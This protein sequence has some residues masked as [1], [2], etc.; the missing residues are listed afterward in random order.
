MEDVKFP[1]SQLRS[2]LRRVDRAASDIAKAL[3]EK[4]VEE[5]RRLAPVLTGALKNSIHAEKGEHENEWLAVAGDEDV[6][7]AVAV[8]FGG[9]DRAA[10]PFFGPGREMAAREHERIIKHHNPFK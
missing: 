2:V 10:H 8:E 9:H 6:D 3:A 5:A 4:Q 1:P 7:Y